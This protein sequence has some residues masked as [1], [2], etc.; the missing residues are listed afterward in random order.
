MCPW[1]VRLVFGWHENSSSHSTVIKAQHHPFWLI[2]AKTKTSTSAGN[3]RPWEGFTGHFDVLQN[4]SLRHICIIFST[5]SRNVDF[6]QGLSRSHLLS[7]NLQSRELK[8][9]CSPL[10]IISRVWDFLYQS[11]T[12]PLKD[13]VINWAL[14]RS[15]TCRAAGGRSRVK[16]HVSVARGQSWRWLCCYIITSRGAGLC[17]AAE[18]Q[19]KAL[20]QPC[21]T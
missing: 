12:Y 5:L 20:T 3:E 9:N 10:S 17:P 1:A 19:F 6:L 7:I 21:F 15:C 16:P 8:H 11:R 13:I 14:K 4:A 18:L 2:T